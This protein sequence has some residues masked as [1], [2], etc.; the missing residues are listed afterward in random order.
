MVETVLTRRRS[1]SG[2]GARLAAFLNNIGFALALGI[3]AIQGSAYEVTPNFWDG[4]DDDTAVPVLRA[5]PNDESK[6]FSKRE[7]ASRRNPG[8]VVGS[9]SVDALSATTRS[10]LRI[11]RDQHPLPPKLLPSPERRASGNAPTDPH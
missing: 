3:A 2:W 7:K 4:V 5:L 6:D 10:A 1:T 9:T 11:C 8:E